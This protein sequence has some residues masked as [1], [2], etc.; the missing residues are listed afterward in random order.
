MRSSITPSAGFALGDSGR[1]PTALSLNWSA[2]A[3]FTFG[4]YTVDVSANGTPGTF[5][6]I[7]VITAQ[8]TTTYVATQLTPGGTYFWQVTENGFFG[9]QATNVLSVAQPPLAVLTYWQPTAA[10][11]VFNW[12]NNASYGGGIAFDSY[13]LFEG[14]GGASPTAV[15]TFPD[16]TTLTYTISGLSSGTA[17]AAYLNTTDCVSGCGTALPARS[18]SDSNV[19]TFGTPLPLSVSVVAERTLVDTGQ[20]NLYLCSPSG[21][22]SPFTFTWDFG[23]GTFLPAGSS[24]AHSYAT[25]GTQTITC[26]VT[27]SSASKATAATSVL[28]NPAPV[29]DISVNRTAADVGQGLTFLCAA[30]GGT[31]PVVLTWTLGDGGTLTVGNGSHTYS[32]AGH[33][34]AE[35]SATDATSTV[36]GGSVPLNISPSLSIAASANS[37][38]AAPGTPLSFRAVATN[39]SGGFNGFRWSFGD[40][41][42]SFP[43]ANV[44][45]A[46]ASSANFSVVAYAKD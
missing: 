45:H 19:V 21:G 32:A 28:V 24:L 37:Y 36:A 40:V 5:N 46:F 29:L 3:D 25:A 34:L 9:S 10:S 2:T 20:N 11:V 39:G 18:S 13:V 1:S 7:S 44:A 27:D 14:V 22:I 6:T 16:V 33:Y 31:A 17:Y 15:A 41:A 35:C 42:G 12:T 30:S 26:R 8:S 4:N 43:G 23:N 38:R